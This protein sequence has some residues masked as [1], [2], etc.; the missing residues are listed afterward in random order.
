MS[1]LLAGIL[2]EAAGKVGAPIVKGMLEKYV[3]GKAGEIGGEI[4]DV[5]AGKAGVS[6]ADLPGLPADELGAAVQAAEPVA[7]ELVLAEVEQQREANRLMLAEMDKE[8][9]TWTWAWRPAWMWLLAFLWTYALVLR[10]LVNAAV[11]AA[12]EAVDV[13]M[14]M[15]LTGAYLALYMGGHTVKDA[16]QRWTGR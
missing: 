10:P 12:I 11:G 5:I 6:P 3:G 9:G 14:L 7:A 2:I 4:I 1:G 8:G 15:T 16:L 13:S